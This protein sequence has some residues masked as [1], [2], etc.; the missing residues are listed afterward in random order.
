MVVAGEARRGTSSPHWPWLTRC[1]GSPTRYDGHRAGHRPRP[2]DS[3]VPERGYPLELIPPV[4][5]PRKPTAGSAA[6]AGQGARLG[7]QD[8]GGARRHGADV[9]VGFGGYVALPAYLGRWTGAATERVPMVV[10]EANA[11]AGHREQGRGPV[12]ARVLAAVPDSGH[13]R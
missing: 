2:G 10:H 3:L 8:Q 7:G 12:A 13:A 9:I 6:A 5:L 4:P 11:K 1:G